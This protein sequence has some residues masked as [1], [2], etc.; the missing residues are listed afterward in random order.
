ME[1]PGRFSTVEYCG[2]E[3]SNESERRGRICKVPICRGKQSIKTLRE[4]SFQVAGPKVFN[5]LPKYLRKI[6]RNSSVDFKEE[7]DLFLA[8]LPDQPHIGDQVPHICD[9]VTA[10][11]SN[12]LVDV[13]AH[14]NAYGGG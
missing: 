13:L 9:Q 11:P 4:Q 8:K 12:S 6:K 7:L 3:E 14:K 10:K 5:S 1:D 2:V